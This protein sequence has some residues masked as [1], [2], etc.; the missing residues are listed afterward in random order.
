MAN[1]TAKQL[2]CLRCL[3]A[4][5]ASTWTVCKQAER[6]GTNKVRCRYEWADA[7]FRELRGKGLIVKAGWADKMGRAV[8]SI[9]D[10]GLAALQ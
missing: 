9:T 7:P 3:A 2:Y 4:G 6:D 10:A 5:N 8:H 1:L